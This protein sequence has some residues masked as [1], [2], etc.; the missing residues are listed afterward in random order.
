MRSIS[1]IAELCRTGSRD[2]VFRCRSTVTVWNYKPEDAAQ[3][4]DGGRNGGG[5]ANLRESER[6]KM[7]LVLR[8]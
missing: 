8:V 4:G 1:E 3:M 2:H 6:V 7:D 5:G